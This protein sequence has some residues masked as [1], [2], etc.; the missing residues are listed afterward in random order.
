ML[1]IIRDPSEIQ[2]LAGI[3]NELA[4]HLMN[5]LLRHEW[6]V[7]CAE[8]FYRHDQIRIMISNSR[9]E[10][11]AIA[12]FALTRHHGIKNF[13]LL[14]TSAHSEPSGFIY[15]DAAALEESIKSIINM[16]RTVLLSRLESESPEVSML[17]RVNKKGAF[18][19][20]RDSAGSPFLP[21][22]TSWTEFEAS[23]SSRSRYDLRRARKRADKIG[24]VTFEIVSPG[25]D[26]LDQYLEEIYQVE[27]SGWKGRNAT[28]MLFDERMKHFF[29]LY[30]RAA[31]RLGTLRLCFL[32]INSKPAAVMLAVELFNRY[33]VLK[34]GYDEA[35]SSCS[36]GILLVHETIRHAFDNRL[37]AYEFL[38]SDAPWIHIW[39]EQQ[40]PFVT[41]R[42]YPFSISG[43]F[44]LG[45]DSTFALSSK[46]LKM[47]YK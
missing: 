45:I 28:A 26:M 34:I 44:S 25:P 39:T 36:P 6:F 13:E 46:A 43:Q 32:R 10:I 47:V 33:W 42:I 9:G 8:A 7:A 40:H 16:G 30:S 4:D 21:I 20:M 19:V 31:C 11:D 24:K 18:I 17:R 37:E 27:A 5:P 22:A 23:V 12:P 3:W 2:P 35:F 38:G 15:K 14:G 29:Q 1:E 41:A